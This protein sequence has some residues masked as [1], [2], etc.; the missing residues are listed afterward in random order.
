MPGDTVFTRNGASSRARVCPRL[1]TAAF[2]AP[3]TEDPDM[4]LKATTPENRV[5]EPWGFRCGAA[6]LAV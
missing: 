6:Y 2:T 5:M 3:S 1:A 4:A